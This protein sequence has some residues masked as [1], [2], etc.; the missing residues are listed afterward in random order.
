MIYTFGDKSKQKVTLVTF[1][2][3][4]Y[5]FSYKNIKII[6]FIQAEPKIKL[7][8]VTFENTKE[9]HTSKYR[10]IKLSNYVLRND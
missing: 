9:E 6:N 8:I 10:K 4:K 2:F 5:Q 3:F 7:Y 1:F